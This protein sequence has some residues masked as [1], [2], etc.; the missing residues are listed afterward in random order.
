[1]ETKAFSRGSE[2][3][4]WDLHI[5]TPKSICNSY[6]G[7]NKET[8]DKFIEA[9]ERLPKEVSVIGINDYYFIDGYEMIMKY[10]KKGRLANIEKIFPILEFRIDTFGSGNENNLQKIN[11]HILFN[12][13]EDDV[14]NEIK[15]VNMEFIDMIHLTSLDIHSTKKL[16]R[17]NFISEGG[18]LQEGFSN[19]IPSTKDVFKILN[20]KTWEDKI[21][22]LLGYKEWSNLEKNQQLKPFKEDLYSKVG[23]FFTSNYETLSESQK[24]LDEFGKKR[25]LH[26][27]DIHG[28]DKLDTAN[29]DDIGNYISSTKYFCNTW[30]KADPTFEGVKQVLFEPE[31]RVR[32]QEMNPDNKAGYLVIDTIVLEEPTFWKQEIHLN[33]YLNTI[34]GGRSTGKSFLLQC[35]AKK[36]DP[37]IQIKDDKR[38]DFV[39]EHYEKITV[40]WKYGE[41][42]SPKEI[43]YFP[44]NY[45]IGLAENEQELDNLVDDIVKDKDKNHRLDEYK[46][47]CIENK[48]IIADLVN[49]LFYI[50]REI[51]HKEKILKEKG[52]QEG[53]Q[54][55]ID[56]LN[57]KINGI[58]INS[59]IS[60]EELMEYNSLKEEILKK[61]E[62]INA[63][64]NDVDGLEH[65]DEL[66]IFTNY[67][68]NTLFSL[69][70]EIQNELFSFINKMKDEFQ[71]KW[72]GRIDIIKN[73]LNESLE[74]LFREINDIQNNNIYKKGLTYSSK[75]KE[76]KELQEQLKIENEKL[77]FIKIIIDQIK[78]YSSKKDNLFVEIIERHFMYFSKIQQLSK[79]LVYQYSDVTI[80]SKGVFRKK[81]MIDFLKE[82]HDLRGVEK[83]NYID[84]FVSKYDRDNIKNITRKYLE[85]A[86]EENIEYKNFNESSLV[87][88]ELLSENWY[89][90][91]YNIKYENDSFD[92]MS[93]GKKSFVILKLLLDFSDKK[94]PIL[95]D[96]PEDNLDN[97][98]IY[99]ELVQ[100]LRK[101]KQERQLI[102]V[103][104]N[105]NIVV[106]ADSEN[107][108]VANQKGAKSKN[109]NDSKFQYVNGALENTKPKDNDEEY[110]LESQGIR[111]HVCEILEGGIEAF[112]ERERKYGI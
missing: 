75:N 80:K 87:V 84:D 66:D 43:M 60:K 101:K 31:S 69:S 100:Y 35:I 5:H 78:S 92:D 3:R 65:L 41:S 8:W 53:I 47:F 97:R 21:F 19:L 81:E 13:N 95:L 34:I 102:I 103:T 38:K 64:Q 59:Q 90:V 55:E 77:N 83:Q 108:I 54:A 56:K 71:T 6:G 2:W 27:L 36:I 93:Q 51:K 62:K 42:S 61:Q 18:S 45:I 23:A 30:V 67:Y 37:N 11:L 82:R 89:K 96:Q 110:I 68:T 40:K 91:T 29:K 9:L 88:L 49:Q 24:W 105:S 22:L 25:L 33:S 50:N 28:F 98:A 1:M 106:S 73:R 12:L 99:N 10:R 79:E 107:V 7:D 57:K 72:K 112:R 15:K 20:S 39:E 85:D 52:D 17:D 104:H 76:Y 26:S 58:N 111:E 44:Q 63:I 48:R 109:K 74:N 16:S 32:I 4:K 46:N 86:L 94:C 70:N 14:D